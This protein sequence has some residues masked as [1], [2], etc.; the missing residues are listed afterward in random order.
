MP[1]CIDFETAEIIAS[2]LQYGRTKAQ[3]YG[4]LSERG[5]PMDK[6]AEAV[7]A[8]ERDLG[9]SFLAS[10]VSTI[11]ELR[12]WPCDPTFLRGLAQQGHDARTIVGLLKGSASP[13]WKRMSDEGV[14]KIVTYVCKQRTWR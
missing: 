14:L 3:I 7:T 12:G 1:W 10:S 11:H 13:G 9:T 6:A 8:V 2:M 5:W 4:R